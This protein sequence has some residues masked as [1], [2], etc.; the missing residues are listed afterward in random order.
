MS[1]APKK[2]LQI[3]L[4]GIVIGFIIMIV[5]A[6]MVAITPFKTVDPNPY[7]SVIDSMGVVYGV[8]FGVGFV[9]FITFVHLFLEDKAEA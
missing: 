5:F 9:I 4:T 8:L 1:P 2:S 6:V 3:D 7:N